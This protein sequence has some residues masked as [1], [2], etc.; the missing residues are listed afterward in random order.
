MSSISRTPSPGILIFAIALVACGRSE[1]VRET[2]L[3]AEGRGTAETAPLAVYVVN[4]P[5]RYFAERI[6]GDQVEVTFPAPAD[7][8][9][10]YWSP[11]PDTVAA[12]QQADLILLNGAGYAG[13]VQRA[14]LPPSKLVGTSAAFRDRLVPLAG[15]VAHTHGPEGEHSHK[16]TAFT[17]WLDPTLAAL[18]ARAIADAFSRARP[19][20]EEAFQAGLEALE[21]DLRGL[22]EELAAATAAFDGEPLLFSHPVYQY[23]ERRYEL[24]GRSLHWEP[25]QVPDEGMWRELEELLAS[26]QARWMIWEG[27]PG[28]E[29]VA[30]LAAAGLRSVVFEPCANVPEDG[31]FL[32]LM[33]RNLAA[34][35][36]ASGG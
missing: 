30:R 16:G 5:L 29:A 13:W 10:A 7:V 25:D 27:T 31:D 14:T 4:Y 12:Y 11:D 8:D 9:P 26:H 20:Q 34:L 35:D 19:M 15:D 22:D 17:I 28:E 23:L 3:E 2:L 21:A 1:P 36:S 6:G 32:A 24:N 18:Q 33:R